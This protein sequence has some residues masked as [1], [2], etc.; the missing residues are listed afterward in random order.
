MPPEAR[1]HPILAGS[2]L[3]LASGG[4]ADDEGPSAEGDPPPAQCH[5]ELPC[6]S[7][8][9]NCLG[10]CPD[11][12]ECINGRCSCEPCT[13][14]AHCLE[15]TG[16]SGLVCI[17]E[18]CW[19]SSCL[20]DEDCPNFAEG[21]T[22]RLLEPRLGVCEEGVCERVGALLLVL[23][24]GGC[25]DEEGRVGRA[26]ARFRLNRRVLGVLGWGR[27][28]RWTAPQSPAASGCQRGT[29]GGI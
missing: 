12:W 13:D 29:G 26:S 20:E 1:H 19:I 6:P 8:L 28:A 18:Q 14:D 24:Q 25:A 27:K 16:R 4:C 5:L 9:Q 22:C 3:L 17:N 21:G 2:D 23:A 11:G 7:R 15:L 10:G